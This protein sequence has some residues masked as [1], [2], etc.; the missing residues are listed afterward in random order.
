MLK[1][2]LDSQVQFFKNFSYYIWRANIINTFS[3]FFGNFLFSRLILSRFFL[4]S[5][6]ESEGNKA[7]D[8]RLHE[9]QKGCFSWVSSIHTHNHF[10]LPIWQFDHSPYVFCTWARL[11]KKS[12]ISMWSNHL[13]ILMSNIPRSLDGHGIFSCCS[14]RS[15]LTPIEDLDCNSKHRLILNS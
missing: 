10:T 3:L 8:W 2:I 13:K 5:F 6:M 9:A 1:V 14:C 15:F 7:D 4:G 11:L 12:Q